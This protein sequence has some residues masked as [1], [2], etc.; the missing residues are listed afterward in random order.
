MLHCLADVLL[1]SD[2][3][4]GVMHADVAQ[5]AERWI[6]DAAMEL[7]ISKLQ[8]LIDAIRERGGGAYGEGESGLSNK[9]L[10]QVKEPTPVYLAA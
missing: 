5:A 9:E 2:D 7:D 4:D 8:P 6:D 1:Y 10:L 3:H